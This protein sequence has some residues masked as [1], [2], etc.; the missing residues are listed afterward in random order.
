MD[1]FV[2]HI[3]YSEQNRKTYVGFTT[4]LISRFQS[5]NALSNKGWTVGYLPWKVV[6]VELYGTK[7]EAMSRE[8]ELKTGKGRDFIK[9]LIQQI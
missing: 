4:D 8:K 3:L 2:V 7:R 1:K 6:H 5:H 9:R